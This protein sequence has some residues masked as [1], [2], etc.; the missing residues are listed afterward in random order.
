MALNDDWGIQ[1]SLTRRME[2]LYILSPALKDRA[3]VKMPLRGKRNVELQFLSMV[4]G[5][6]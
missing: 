3:K 1:S 5:N 2:S 4:W 6:D